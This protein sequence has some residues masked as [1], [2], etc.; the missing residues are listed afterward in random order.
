MGIRESPIDYP[1]LI[2]ILLKV[3]KYILAC[4]Y[5]YLSRAYIKKNIVFWGAGIPLY[6]EN[7][8]KNIILFFNKNLENGYY[9]IY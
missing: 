6:V 3:Y 4:M 2:I 5:S 9:G 1:K 7:I 8:F